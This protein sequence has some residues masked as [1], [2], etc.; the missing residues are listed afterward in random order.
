MIIS[1]LKL[2]GIENIY[3]K[4]YNKIGIISSKICGWCVMRI[5]ERLKELRKQSGYLQKDIA[6]YLNIS[7]SAYGYYEQGRNEPD[8]QTIVKLASYYNV[9]TDYL[10]CKTDIENNSLTSKESNILRLYREL[11]NDSKN[12]VYGAIYALA[13]KKNLEN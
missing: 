10:L 3:V 2:F 4:M 13:S 12:I 7:K 9:S 8:I 11:D 1:C 6:D 5:Y